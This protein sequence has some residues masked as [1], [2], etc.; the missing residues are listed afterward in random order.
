[1]PDYR[2]S[3]DPELSTKDG[4][5]WSGRWRNSPQGTIRRRRGRVPGHSGQV[6]QGVAHG[7]V[8]RP[9]PRRQVTPALPGQ[10][11][12]AQRPERA[13]SGRAD[14][15][16]CRAGRLGTYPAAALRSAG[17]AAR[18]AA[19]TGAGTTRSWFSWTGWGSGTALHLDDFDCAPASSLFAGRLA[20]VTDPCR[21]RWAR[22]SPTP[23]DTTVHRV[24]VG[25]RSSPATRLHAES[26]RANN[27]HVY[28]A[29]R[30]SGLDRVGGHRLRHALA[31]EL[32]CRG[33]PL[34]E[35]AQVLRHSDLGTT[36]GYA[37]IDRIALRGLAQS[38]PVVGR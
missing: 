7:R 17:A 3:P 5:G 13:R 21:F 1:V 30:R 29:C 28:R 35:I 22:R 10:R 26:I 11:R 25:T 33:G 32:L 24:S 4:A 12:R 36:A 20:A 9:A 6:D 19:A 27:E 18:R 38:W 15:R 34:T 31:S 16:I 2:C 8:R 14:L 37:K 23:S